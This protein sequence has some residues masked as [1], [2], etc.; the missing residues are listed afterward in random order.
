MKG[1]QLLIGLIAV[2]I[3]ASFTMPAYPAFLDFNIDATHPVTAQISY[4]GGSSPLVGVNIGVDK[5]TGI[6][7]PLNTGVDR[8][9]FGIETLVD[10]NSD[11]DFDDAGER[12]Q[13]AALSFTTGIWTGNIGN[14]ANFS[15]GGTLDIVGGIDL[16]NDGDVDDLG[17]IPLGT[18]LLSATFTMAQLTFTGTDYKLTFGEFADDKPIKLTDFYGLPSTDTIPYIGYL[19]L[20]F[21]ASGSPPSDFISTSVGSGNVE[22]SPIPEPGTLLLLGS[23]L[24]GLAGYAKLRLKRRNS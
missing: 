20:G 13:N 1:L 24:V 5:V 10:L 9:L 12:I 16:N 7:T 19:N 17:D 22:N 4:A 14:I 18:S 21:R 11:G 23:G 2:L 6:G 3:L 8:F 15:G